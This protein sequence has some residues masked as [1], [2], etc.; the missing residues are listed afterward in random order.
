MGALGVT[1]KLGDEHAEMLARQIMASETPYRVVMNNKPVNVL[2]QREEVL[3]WLKKDAPRRVKLRQGDSEEQI[4]A[5]DLKAVLE[6]IP[7]L[8]VYEAMGRGKVVDPA[9]V[10]KR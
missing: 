10:Q 2:K 4:F 5:S 6:K 3:D 7:N 1:A 9:V 8:Q